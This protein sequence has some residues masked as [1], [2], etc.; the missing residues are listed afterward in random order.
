[1]R[2]SAWFG[3]VM[4]LLL[5]V[6]AGCGGGLS[7]D[8]KKAIDDYIA[9]ANAVAGEKDA[10]KKKKL[11]DELKPL[12]DKITAFKDDKKTAYDKEYKTKVEEAQKKMADAAK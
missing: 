3:I 10:D 5:F 8:D 2:T 1:M 6:I 11:V 4:S 9:K 12:G 7:A